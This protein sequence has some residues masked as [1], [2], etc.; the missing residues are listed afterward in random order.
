MEDLN[1]YIGYGIAFLMAFT[2]MLIELSNRYGSYFQFTLKSF[3]SFL[4]CGAYGLVGFV[5]YWLYQAG[6]KSFDVSANEI[7]NDIVKTLVSAMII[8]WSAKGL[9]DAPILP[10]GS[11]DENNEGFRFRLLINFIF[12]NANSQFD[13]IIA[14]KQRKYFEVC[15]QGFVAKNGGGTNKNIK[16]IFE[17][18]V[19]D[20]LDVHPRYGGGNATEI[21]HFNTIITQLV[22]E[23]DI[24][25][26]L[27]YAYRNLG[28]NLFKAIMD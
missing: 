22:K 16:A 6:F 25:G 18:K 27:R 4:Y 11:K 19:Y 23:S 14:R 20:F 28:Y 17:K 7:D 3:Y 15:R 13:T 5:G 8:G 21:A 12:L 26:S 1:L 9:L 10:A 2:S 24:E